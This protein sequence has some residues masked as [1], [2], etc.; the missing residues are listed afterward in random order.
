MAS[1]GGRSRLDFT[2]LVGTMLNRR[3]ASQMVVTVGGFPEEMFFD[4]TQDE[5]R[6]LECAIWYVTL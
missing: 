1:Y 5:R 4:L 3:P 6:D 2:H